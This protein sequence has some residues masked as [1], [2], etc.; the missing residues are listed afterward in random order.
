MAKG[1]S[2]T[3]AQR[4]GVDAAD[5]LRLIAREEDET[6]THFVCRL[7][8]YNI[9]MLFVPPGAL[10]R[11]ARIADML[12]IS[13]TP[14]H[15]GIALLEQMLLVDVRPQSATHVSRISYDLLRQSAFMRLAI[16]PTV[17]A[18][19][20]ANISVEDVARL[21]QNVEQQRQTGDVYRFIELDNEFHRIIYAAA[22]KEYVWASLRRVSSHYDRVRHMGLLVG[23]DKMSPDEHVQLLQMTVFDRKVDATMFEPLLREHLFHFV[24]FFDELTRAYPDH[25]DLNEKGFSPDT[26]KRAGWL[27]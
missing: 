12:G 17:F 4:L 13:K 8:Y 21:W 6:A 26:L 14:V 24:K 5:S 2:R 1:L 10:I 19:A 7:L 15:Q 23:M 16:E 3:P 20:A 22:G 11:E 25:F 9:V 18:Q 27:L